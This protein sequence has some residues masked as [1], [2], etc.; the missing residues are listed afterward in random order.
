M[1]EHHRQLKGALRSAL[2]AER[3]GREPGEIARASREIA[4]SV[5]GLP[6]FQ[7]ARHLVAYAAGPGEVDPAD[8]VRA[9]VARGQ[10][11][12]FP[13]VVGPTL[14][15]LA[16]P[17]AGLRPGTYGLAEPP[18]GTP[19]D[20]A[21]ADV[22]F[23]VP[24]LAF[25]PAGTRLGRGGGHYDRAL[26]DHPAALRIGLACDA[27]IQSSLPRDPWDQP[28]DAV[29]TER[30]VLWATAGRSGVAFVENLS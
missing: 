25:D 26:A 14:E 19:L 30:R 3:R 20:P 11:V 27:H 23:L 28:M 29:V 2:R 1:G 22:V 5:L 9:G 17:P 6:V 4:T 24:G 13:R 16:C 15:F 10:M 21:S 8:L 12:Y 7:R 18:G